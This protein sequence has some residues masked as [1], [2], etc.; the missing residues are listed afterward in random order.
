MAGPNWNNRHGSADDLIAPAERGAVNACPTFGSKIRGPAINLSDPYMPNMASLNYIPQPPSSSSSP[1]DPSS[2]LAPSSA[3]SSS[4]AFLPITFL[5]RA[6]VEV[7]GPFSSFTRGG[8]RAVFSLTTGNL[9]CFRDPAS[10]F[11][12]S[13]FRSGE[14]QVEH[15][16]GSLQFPQN[17]ARAYVREVLAIHQALLNAFLTNYSGRHTA[18]SIDAALSRIQSE[19][20]T[21]L[22]SDAMAH[23]TVHILYDFPFLELRHHDGE[24]VM[25]QVLITIE[26]YQAPWRTRVKRWNRRGSLNTMNAAWYTT[27]GIKDLYNFEE[28]VALDPISDSRLMQ[29]QVALAASSDVPQQPTT[30]SAASSMNLD[31]LMTCDAQITT[32]IPAPLN[33]ANQSSQAISSL[34]P[35][36]NIDAGNVLGPNGSMV[37]FN[38]A[39]ID[40][41]PLAPS[42]TDTLLKLSCSNKQL[43][44]NPSS[45]Q[46]LVHILLDSSTSNSFQQDA[47]TSFTSDDLLATDTPAMLTPSLVIPEHQRMDDPASSE[48][49]DNNGDSIFMVDFNLQ[50]H[51]RPVLNLNAPKPG[52]NSRHDQLSTD[53]NHQPSNHQANEVHQKCEE[54]FVSVLGLHSSAVHH[55]MEP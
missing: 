10:L 38:D 2:S 20:D 53:K 42:S 55:Q 7:A 27:T 41:S 50:D 45:S 8:Q 48:V 33:G 49:I 12:W 34:V 3:L 15:F 28:V 23:S 25:V 26:Y 19:V 17:M 37:F 6:F 40:S 13:G 29:P 54:F 46:G 44:V 5:G 51:E 14:L 52:P 4:T 18:L 22:Y 24:E 39:S 11:K 31:A 9:S 32:V 30:L 36:L 47:Q 21:H 35:D 1:A 43:H 16:D